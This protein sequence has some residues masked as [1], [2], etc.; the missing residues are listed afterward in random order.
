MI[1]RAGDSFG[2]VSGS[3]W[4]V[5]R[6][7]LSNRIDRRPVHKDFATPCRQVRPPARRSPRQATG[8]S[9]PRPPSR[10]P[11]SIAWK[12]KKVSAGWHLTR[13]ENSRTREQ[14]SASSRDFFPRQID[15]QYSPIRPLGS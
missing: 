11:D 15:S 6:P 14:H 10:A 5:L 12:D 7:P 9:Q 2:I 8:I 4:L 13:G 1:G 3:R